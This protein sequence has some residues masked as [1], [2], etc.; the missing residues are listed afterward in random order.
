MKLIC[1]GLDLS[2]A[3]LKVIKATATR[4]TNPILEGIKLSAREDTL[5]LSA[6]DLEISIEKTIPA[7][8]KIPGETVV[9]GK[10]FADFVKKLSNEQIELSL[11]QANTLKIKYTDS[12]GSLSCMNADEFPVIK[13]IT[14]PEKINIKKTDLKNLIDKTIFSVAVD[15]ARPIL[16]GCLFE[17]VGNQMTA[18]ALDGY[19]LA[20]VK[21]EVAATANKL[22]CIVPAR[23]LSEI[24]KLISIENED[25][26]IDILVGQNHMQISDGSVNILTR[27]LEGE[28]INYKQVIPASTTTT[29]LVNKAQLE[30]GL[31]RA[32]LLARMD[33][34][35]L[36]K[37]DIRDKV[38]TLT[39]A[40]NIGN[41]TENITISLEGK[42]LSIA[43]NARYLSDCMHTITDEFIKINFSSQIA[44]CTICSAE[45]DKYLYLI[46]P[47]RIVD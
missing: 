8:V 41:V 4:T 16:K 45:D 44:P 12:E 19:R 6:T 17:V 3:V 37:F 38:L 24:S 39:S 33:K 11:S 40:S 10:F 35:N 22:N 47:V 20:M 18:V 15:D 30:D 1:E 13:E 21:A 5:T 7:D 43:F 9:P 31:E 34:N 14:S 25:D 32:S 27:L 36:V 28:F 23:S 42:D 2:D 26:T 46:L 29:I